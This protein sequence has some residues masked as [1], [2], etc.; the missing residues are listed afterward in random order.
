MKPRTFE[1]FPESDVC[2]V[3]KTNAD[4]ECMLIPIDGTQ[5]DHI[6]QAVPVHIWC[7]IVT[8]YNKDIGLL[9]RRV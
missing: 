1:H 6:V 3:C 8:G 2:P 4:E 7:A 5:K 9:Y